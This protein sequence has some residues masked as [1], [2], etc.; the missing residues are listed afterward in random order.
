MKSMKKKDLV[1]H[2]PHYTFG[3]IECIDAIRAALGPAGFEAYLQGQIL[4]YTWR[5]RHKGQ[6][7][8]DLGKANWYLL[9]LLQEVKAPGFEKKS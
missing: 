1:N 4:K 9:R 3:D 2:P 5:W 6:C 8:D 7:V